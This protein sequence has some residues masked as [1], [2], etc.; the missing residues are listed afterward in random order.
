MQFTLTLWE[1]YSALGE[2]DG[3]IRD[4]SA[5]HLVPIL[6]ALD[7]PE[8]AGNWKLTG[9][10]PQNINCGQEHKPWRGLYSPDGDPSPPEA[11]CNPTLNPIRCGK[12]KVICLTL[13]WF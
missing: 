4:G 2:H 1:F 7:S 13:A 11:C 3:A 12:T 9:S 5:G 10:S 6:L 8:W